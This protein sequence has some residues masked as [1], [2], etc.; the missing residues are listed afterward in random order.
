MADGIFFVL[1]LGMRRK[2]VNN[3]KPLKE[4]GTMYKCMLTMGLAGML[5]FSCGK[6]PASDKF[7]AKDG[8]AAFMATEVQD[9]NNVAEDNGLH[10]AAMPESTIGEITLKP[11]HYDS[12]SHAFIR[13]VSAIYANDTRTR[14]DTVWYYGANG[15]LSSP[16]LAAVDSFKHVRNVIVSNGIHTANIDFVMYGVVDKSN[17]SDIIVTRNGSSIGSFDGEVFRTVTIT[18]V[19]RHRIN[20]IGQFPVSGNIFIDRPFRTIDVDFTGNDT[21]TVM[22]TKKLNKK[23]YTFKVINMTN[24]GTE[25]ES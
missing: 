16:N 14:V 17:P 8:N 22:V 6:N 12:L 4:V 11:W 3:S 18:N 1:I 23:T 5:L 7:N 20:G 9:M 19:V 25:T 13:T 2:I 15:L 10:K 24:G 21:A